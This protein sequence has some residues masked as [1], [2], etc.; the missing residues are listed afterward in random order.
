MLVSTKR[1]AL[2]RANSGR[3]QCGIHTITLE[4][5]KQ[6]VEEQN[7]KCVFTGRI[8]EWTDNDMNK[9]SIDRIDSSKG[10][11]P[12]NIQ[13]VTRVANQAKSDMSDKEFLNFI[14]DIYNT[15]I[16]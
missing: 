8:L 15:R 13:I 12:D 5:V 1:T 14:K 3:I 2:K 16:K 6:K 10:Y 9:A 11:T 7:G 4:D